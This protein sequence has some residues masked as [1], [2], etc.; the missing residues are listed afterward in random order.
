MVGFQRLGG[1]S[2]A[3]E[4]LKL[5]WGG[6]LTSV[7]LLGAVYLFWLMFLGPKEKNLQAQANLDELL[8]TS[9]G[10]IM[11]VMSRLA[12]S[13]FMENASSFGVWLRQWLGFWIDSALRAVLLDIP[14][15]FDVRLSSI[16]PHSWFARLLTV[17]FKFL[18]TAGLVSFLWS[19][20][21]RRFWTEIFSGT[22]KDCY[23]KCQEL[24]DRDTLQLEQQGKVEVFAPRRSSVAMVDF[25][26]AFDEEAFAD[27]RRKKE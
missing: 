5:W 2:N 7:L 16:E 15:I 25:I 1:E 18:I 10:V 27:E 24:L 9:I 6:F 20:Y 12:R 8:T 11:F 19:V 26:E 13:S 4:S 3:I 14:E 17:F 23:L 22:V 21:R